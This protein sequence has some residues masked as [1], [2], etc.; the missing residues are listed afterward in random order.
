MRLLHVSDTHLGQSGAHG[1]LAR[2]AADVLARA[3]AP[4]L[5]GDVDAVLH[6]GDLFDRSSPCATALAAARGILGEVARRVPVVVIAGNH[7]RKGVGASL[8]GVP[9]IRVVDSPAVVDVGGVRFGALPYVG[10]AAIW[11]EQ[12]AELARRGF[13]VLAAHQSFDGQAVPGFVFRAGRVAET[14]SGAQVP[15]SVRHV[16]SGH[17]HPR[18]V[19]VVGAATVVC[20]GSTVR[21]SFREGH[22]PKCAARWDFGAVPTWRFVPLGSPVWVRVRGRADLLAVS[23]GTVV[24]LA[25]GA[26]PDLGSAASARGAVLHGSDAAQTLPELPFQVR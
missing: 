8:S 21:T 24:R 2:I 11:A 18:Q 7:D 25:P 3:L 16:L 5:A 19:V 17:I 6:T 10:D 26:D 22:A 1:A 20:V 15:P 23:D 9:G 12:A 14:V 4:A 13:D